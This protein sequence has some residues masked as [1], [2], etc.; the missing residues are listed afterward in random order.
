M[1]NGSVEVVE[2]DVETDDGEVVGE[3][4]GG[5]KLVADCVGGE[6]LVE[7]VG[8]GG[9][10]VGDVVEE[11]VGGGVQLQ[12]VADVLQVGEERVPPAFGGEEAVRLDEA[13]DVQG[14]ILL[15]SDLHLGD[16]VGDVGEGALLEAGERSG[17]VVVGGRRGGGGGGAVGWVRR[18]KDGVGRGGQEVTGKREDRRTPLQ[19]REAS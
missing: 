2:G 9:L 19:S 13:Q 16:G 17:V 11:A 18:A 10:G 5:V 3:V 7:G 14:A 8:G 15:S 4:T 6:A 12:I 1:V